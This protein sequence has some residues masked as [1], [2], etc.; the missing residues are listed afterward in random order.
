MDEKLT[1]LSLC[2]TFSGALVFLGRGALLHKFG[3]LVDDTAMTPFPVE[4]LRRGWVRGKLRGICRMSSVIGV[5]CQRLPRLKH[6][7][8]NPLVRATTQ[9]SGLLHRCAR[10]QVTNATAW[11]RWMAKTHPKVWII[12]ANNTQASELARRHASEPIAGRFVARHKR[13]KTSTWKILMQP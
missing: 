5:A 3:A 2:D 7:P 10:C 6:L 13:K 9:A 11:L 4:G 8:G 12:M 1:W